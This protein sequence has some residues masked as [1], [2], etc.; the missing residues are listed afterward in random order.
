MSARDAPATR[1]AS[2]GSSR[3]SRRRARSGRGSRTSRITMAHGAGGKATQTLIE[4]L[5]VAGVRARRAASPSSADAGRVTVD[6]HGLAMTTD[7][8]VVKP[9]RF[10]G[11]S[12]GELAVNGTVNDLAAGGRPAA[13]DQPRADPRGGPRRRRCCAAEVE[14][15]AARRGGRRGRGRRRRHQGRRARPRRRHVHHHDRGRP[16]RPARDALARRRSSPATGCSSP[17]RS[18]STGPRSCSPAASSSSTPRSSPTRA[19]CG[20][21]PTRC[22]T[23]PARACDCMRDATRGG[24]ATVLNELAR[25]SGVGDRRRARPTSRSRPEVTGACRDARDRPDVRRQR[26]PAGRL[27]RARAPPRRRWRRCAR[28]PAARRR[29][30]SARSGRS[31]PGWC[32]SRR[33]SAAGG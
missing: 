5:L 16:G 17:A 28:C 27:R 9:L 2:S 19:R 18:A 6:G 20:R 29:A 22:S 10:P 11:G 12:I 24:V 13:G 4:G 1:A 31:R 7:T 21:P 15:I 23:P 14:A 25:A 33:R 26:G 3:S 8:F 30:R 32:W